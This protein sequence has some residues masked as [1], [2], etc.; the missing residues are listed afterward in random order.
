MKVNKRFWILVGIVVII[1]LIVL[2]TSGN[3]NKDKES[4]DKDA[5]V[6][7]IQDGEMTV[8]KGEKISSVKSYNGL[9]FSNTE[10]KMNGELTFLTCDVRNSTSEVIET[11]Y[12]DI[13]II[14]NN[15][16]D[17][18]VLG[19]MIQTLKPGETQAF[20]GAILSND[21]ETEAYDI[22]ITEQV[23]QDNTPPEL[24]AQMEAERSNME[25]EQNNNENS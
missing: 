14:N 5:K 9:E 2:L 16:E 24:K 21:K 19:G 7:T 20:S 17:L 25:A 10:I 6:D 12:V 4:T 1:I 8:I 15:G 22:K 23:E 11:Q 3:G 13:H 18:Q